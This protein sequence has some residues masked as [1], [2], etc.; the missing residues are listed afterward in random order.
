MIN[1]LK[2]FNLKKIFIHQ[3]SQFHDIVKFIYILTRH[4]LSVEYQWFKI[5]KDIK[6]YDIIIASPRKSGTNG[7]LALAINIL[8]KGNYISD[9]KTIKS[10]MVGHSPITY[11]KKNETSLLLCHDLPYFKYWKAN[12]KIK[13]IST[14]RL[15][16]DLLTSSLDYYSIRR[17]EPLFKSTYLILYYRFL[18]IKHLKRQLQ[19]IK[20]YSKSQVL[21]INFN[22]LME[23]SNDT[24]SSMANYIN[25]TQFTDANCR[26]IINASEN[27]YKSSF[28]KVEYL[29]GGFSSDC[30]RY[31]KWHD[32]PVVSI[33]DKILR[34]ILMNRS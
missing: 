16:D 14:I 25:E 17:I 34:I 10:Y 13:F 23:L 4:R 32:F 8:S 24:V 12:K 31:K 2:E 9:W 7:L 1:N 18:Q 26:K 28:Q 5:R 27:I 11:Y 33:L 20:F 21:F 22:E 30:K 19:K 15:K 29:S 6:Y 3:K